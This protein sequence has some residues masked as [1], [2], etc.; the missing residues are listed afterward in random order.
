V[1]GGLRALRL[2]LAAA[3]LQ[4]P[5]Q[6]LLFMLHAVLKAYCRAPLSFPFLSQPEANA[7]LELCLRPYAKDH[8]PANR[9]PIR[10]P[11]VLA[12]YTDARQPV[13]SAAAQ[14]QK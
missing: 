12:H 4:V 14:A 9:Q 7:Q 13:A 2:P 1:R 10:Q 3:A 6:T 5:P 8:T 11:P